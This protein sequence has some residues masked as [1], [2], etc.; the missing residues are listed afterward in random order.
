MAHLTSRIASIAFDFKYVDL[1]G[2]RRIS[3]DPYGSTSSITVG[4]LGYASQK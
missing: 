3:D 2:R 1:V 4:R